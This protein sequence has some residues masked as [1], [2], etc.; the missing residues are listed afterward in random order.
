MYI[1][2]NI[3]IYTYSIG[4]VSKVKCS[5]AHHI[6]QCRQTHQEFGG[7]QRRVLPK[8]NTQRQGHADSND[9][10]TMGTLW[11]DFLTVEQGQPNRLAR[12]QNVVMCHNMNTF[13]LY[14]CICT[15]VSLHTSIVTNVFIHTPE[16]IYIYVPP[17]IHTYTNTDVC[18]NI[19]VWVCTHICVCTHV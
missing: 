10:R 14:V 3:Y 13:C 8:H 1:C 5:A 18:M 19:Y 6:Q 2:I 7:V 12:P 15:R 17:Y 4:S 11:R 16:Y 9:V